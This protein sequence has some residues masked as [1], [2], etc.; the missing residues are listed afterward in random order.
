MV[1][2]T[3]YCSKVVVA[4]RAHCDKGPD[5]VLGRLITN[6]ASTFSGTGVVIREFVKYVGPTCNV[7]CGA[8][9]SPHFFSFHF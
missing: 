6:I 9:P 5:L 7:A 3:C 4:L 1:H 8:F 2:G